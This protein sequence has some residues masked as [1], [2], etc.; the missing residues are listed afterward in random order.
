LKSK[1]T[2]GSQY[3]KTLKQPIVKPVKKP[4][5]ICIRLCA[6]NNN[7][8]L[9][10]IP[11]IIKGAELVKNIVSAS[12]EQQIGV[13]TINNSIQE[14]TEITNENSASAEEMSASAEELSAQA[15]QL[16]SL[17]SVFKISKLQTENKIIKPK[18]EYQNKQLKKPD[19]Q[20]KIKQGIKIDLSGK[21]ISDEEFETF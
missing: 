19:K 21:N 3:K 14:L 2:D 9:A 8:A 20:P 16:K 18:K 17:I 1:Q 5:I 10:I 6:F 12:K 11:E 4:E 15:E 13:E 7:R